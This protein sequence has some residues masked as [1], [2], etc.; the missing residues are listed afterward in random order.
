MLSELYFQI[1]KKGKNLEIL[2][3]K[4]YLHKSVITTHISYLS[5]VVFHI[6]PT[7]NILLKNLKN[8][9]TR[10]EWKKRVK[11]S[12]GFLLKIN[13]SV[14]PYILLRNGCW[15][16]LVAYHAGEWTSAGTPRNCSHP[17][18]RFPPMQRSCS[19]SMPSLIRK[20]NYDF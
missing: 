7:V 4:N 1:K 9:E 12:A 6:Y 19:N 15:P 10:K 14:S 20:N 18:F 16:D 3:V 17:Q 2:N 11:L 13:L 8:S 5:N